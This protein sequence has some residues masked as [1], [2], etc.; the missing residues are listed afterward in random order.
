MRRSA[1][2]PSCRGA[3]D[4]PDRRAGTEPS[5]RRSTVLA[6]VVG[7]GV[8]LVLPTEARAVSGGEA[9]A[10]YNQHR[11]TAGLPPVAE[12]AALTEG[13]R[14]HVEYARLN[15]RL[16]HSEDPGLPG[17]SPEGERAAGQSVLSNDDAYGS[18]GGSTWENAPGH[19][20]QTLNPWIATTGVAGGCLNTQ[21]GNTYEFS[22]IASW[23][24]PGDGTDYPARQVVGEDDSPA[25][26]A[27]LDVVQATG[28]HLFFLAAGPG[29]PAAYRGEFVSASLV[30]PDGPVAIR[31]QD[32]SS[33]ISAFLAPGGVI[34]PEKPLRPG[35]TYTASATFQP[36]GEASGPRLPRQG[37]TWRF[38]AVDG[39]V[40]ESF[41][42]TGGT[43]KVTFGAASGGGGGAGGA[44]RPA[45]LGTVRLARRSLSV[46]VE[47]ATTVRATVEERRTRGG[48][49]RWVAVRRV[50]I[51]G[52]AAGSA[53]SPTFRALA[54]GRRYR[55]TVRTSGG[56][57]IGRRTVTARRT[58]PR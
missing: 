50:R 42:P 9:M 48:K 4:A 10:F 51:V 52:L 16:E 19:L 57:L 38:R 7:L 27:G 14:R 58:L 5:A 12:D 34:I 43:G 32:G 36:Y 29:D 53:T 17:Y 55:V 21:G 25:E 39:A 49:R 37:H 15:D 24:Y 28:P 3:A 46:A 56:R 30:G 54:V 41:R 8:L 35:A 33:S 22:K 20:M 13:C 26:I 6:A 11:A 44:S 18:D 45:R 40:S 2:A 47:R 23:G 1:P 31:T